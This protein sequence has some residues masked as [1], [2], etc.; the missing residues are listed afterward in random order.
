MLALCLRRGRGHGGRGGLRAG[1][2]CGRRDAPGL[3]AARRRRGAAVVRHP[4]ARRLR[5]WPG[6]RSGGRDAVRAPLRSPAPLHPVPLR[7]LQRGRSRALGVVRCQ[8]E[9]GGARR[10]GALGT[11]LAAFSA[12]RSQ[13]PGA[14]ERCR[15]PARA[16][17]SSARQRAGGA[18]GVLCCVSCALDGGGQ[19]SWLPTEHGPARASRSKLVSFD[20]TFDHPLRRALGPS[21]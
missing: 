4:E 9:G 18:K 19:S 1:V 7:P 13:R 10:R 3:L 15:A 17:R 6:L 2:V 21:R 20:A 5:R 14:L 11:I 12:A 16:R 8:L